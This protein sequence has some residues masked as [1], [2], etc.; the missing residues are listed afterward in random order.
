[1]KACMYMCIF[2][3]VSIQA[4]THIIQAMYTLTHMVLNIIMLNF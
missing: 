4:Y 2:I 3:F 1:M